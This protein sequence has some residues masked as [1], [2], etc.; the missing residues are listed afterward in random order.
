LVSGE[1]VL[2]LPP[3]LYSNALHAGREIRHEPDPTTTVHNMKRN[4]L[5]LHAPD[6]QATFP[7]KPG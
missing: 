7:G 4:A 3:L 2:V 6:E 5:H 1:R